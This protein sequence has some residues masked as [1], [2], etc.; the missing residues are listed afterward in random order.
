MTSWATYPALDSSRPAGLS[1]KVIGGELRR[2]LGFKGVTITDGLDAGAVKPFGSVGRRAVL[3]ASAGADLILCAT[4]NP[5]N[6]TPSLGI[7]ARN[8]IAS[9]LAARRLSTSAARQAASRILAL[10]S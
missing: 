4:T 3:A 1:P 8:A 9:A 10:R 5:N 6:N 2:R 7:A